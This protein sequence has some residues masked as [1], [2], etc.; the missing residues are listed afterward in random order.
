MTDPSPI[1]CIECGAE[2][3]DHDL[4]LQLRAEGAAECYTCPG[5]TERED[6]L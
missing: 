5:C 1:A 3:E 6:S 4:A 2:C